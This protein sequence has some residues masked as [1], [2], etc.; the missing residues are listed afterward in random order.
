MNCLVSVLFGTIPTGVGPT[1]TPLAGLGFDTEDVPCGVSIAGE[2]GVGMTSFKM[3]MMHMYNTGL[4]ISYNEEKIT[5]N[6][7]NC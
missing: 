3:M 2:L 5:S 7:E 6:E 1:K 4:N